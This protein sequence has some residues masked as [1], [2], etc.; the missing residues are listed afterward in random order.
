MSQLNITSIKNQKGDFGPTLVGY[1]TVSGD[2]NVTGTISGDASGL[3]GISTANIKSD[4][5]NV[6]GVVTATTF[7]GDLEGSITGRAVGNFS[8]EDKLLHNGDNDTTIRFPELDTFTIET[9][10]TE[11]I[12]ITSSGN[13]GIGTTD[14]VAKLDVDGSLNV[15]GVSTLGVTSVSQLNVSSASTFHDKVHLL[16]DDKLHFGGDQGDS[17]DLQIYH[18]GTDSYILDNGTGDLYVRTNGDKLVIDGTGGISKLAE[19]NNQGS[20]DIYYNNSKKFETTG[21]GVSITGGLTA[22]GITTVSG[23]SGN[24]YA[25]IGT[26]TSDK[27]IINREYVSVIE[28]G[29][30]ITLPSSSD[31]SAGDEVIIGVGNFTDTVIG[32]NGSNIMGIAEDST[33]DVA[34]STIVLV[35]IDT[36]TGWRIS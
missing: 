34:N 29:R 26:T 3:T 33:I 6:T 7:D 24:V 14:P 1:T 27:T 9:N 36:Y 13:I 23:I 8:I 22:S 20:V 18:N 10:G 11:R 25:G 30:T 21:T 5:I 17:G 32:R 15:S 35:Y 28:S 19:F 4:T 31:V 12:R 2:L 16:D